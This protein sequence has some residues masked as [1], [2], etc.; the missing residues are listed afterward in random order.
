MITS[1]V[2]LVAGGCLGPIPG[3]V[4]VVLGLTALS[5]MKK[6]PGEVGGKPYAQAGVIIGAISIFFYALLFI[7]FVISVASR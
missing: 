7:W 6:S 3:I 1:L 2:G 4:G 5:Q